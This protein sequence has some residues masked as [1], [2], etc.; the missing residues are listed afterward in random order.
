MRTNPLVTE[1][2]TGLTRPGKAHLHYVGMLLVQAVILLLWWPREDVA[3]V[4][5]A[6]SGPNTLTAVVMTIGITT[7]YQAIRAGAEELMLRGQH[8]LRDWALGTPLRTARLL[9][10]YLA[11]HLVYDLHLLALSAP[12][13]L[14]TFTISGG[15]W[16]P[17][18]W[19]MAAALVQALFYT[20]CGGVV[21]VALGHHRGAAQTAVRTVLIVM[22]AVVGLA[23]PVLSHVALTASLLGEAEPVRTFAAVSD[24]VAFVAA[25]GVLSAILAA[26]LYRLLVRVRRGAA[27]SD[28]GAAAH[29][30]IVS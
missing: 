2:L 11:G 30:A 27:G 20:L 18:G 19:C 7:A 21:Q 5:D 12:L 13:V 9:R 14:M 25:Y 10:G 16:A 6:Q 15:E 24:P 4:L 26:V 22:Y 17:L 3:Q 28:D 8:G 29:G 23:L 1:V